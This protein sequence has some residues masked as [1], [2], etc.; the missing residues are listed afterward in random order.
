MRT[1]KK[2]EEQKEMLKKTPKQHANGNETSSAL[3]CS[4]SSTKLPTEVLDTMIAIS[5]DVIADKESINH[6]EYLAG[7]IDTELRVSHEM[8]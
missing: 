5:D 3:V 2:E 4:C 6:G 7:Q 8:L 1:D